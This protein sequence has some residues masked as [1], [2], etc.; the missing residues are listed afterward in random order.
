MPDEVV[1]NTIE[2]CS[3]VNFAKISFRAGNITV[4]EGLKDISFPIARIFYIYDIPGGENRGAHAH[5]QCRQLIIAA[6][7]SFDVMI[8]DGINSKTINLNR[9]DYGLYVPA[10]IWAAE[11]NFSSGSVCL[12][13]TSHLFDE[14][15]YIRDYSEFTEYKKI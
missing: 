8:D 1:R 4:V 2:N 7:G 12:V 14:K 11:I 9:P 15:D 13:I 3:L 6:S 10:G 5:K